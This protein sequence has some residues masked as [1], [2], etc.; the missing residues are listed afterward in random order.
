MRF[1]KIKRTNDGMFLAYEAEGTDG[2][3]DRF[4]MEANDEP[5]PEM[6]TAMQALVEDVIEICELPAKGK[7]RCLITGISLS[8]DKDGGQSITITCLKQL[9]NASAPLVINT[10]HSN[11]KDGVEGAKLYSKIQK[12]EKQAVAYAK[13]NRAQLNLFASMEAIAA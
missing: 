9:L 10:P 7:D 1:T 13:G 11:V 8:Y 5:A 3:V 4:T 12:I 6:I 2:N